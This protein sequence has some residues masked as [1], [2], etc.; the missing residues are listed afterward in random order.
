MRLKSLLGAASIAIA[1]SSASFALQ[2]GDKY[3]KLSDQM[4]ASGH[5]A[6]TSGTPTEALE[7]FERALVANPASTAAILGLAKAHEAEGR[8]GR[9]LK[10]YRLALSLEP[11]HLEAL[12]SQA[13]AFLKRDMIDRA[14]SNRE[15]LAR[16]CQNGCEPLDVVESALEAHKAKIADAASDQTG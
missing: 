6:L 10:Y 3:Q 11:N 5:A 1:F 4:V 16:L 2:T 8:V 14:E 7:F 15:K 13:L 12:G 9:S